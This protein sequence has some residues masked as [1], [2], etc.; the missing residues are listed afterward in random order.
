MIAIIDY[1]MG[2]LRS[3]QKAL[4]QAGARD[5][6][7]TQ[8][9]LDIRSATHVVL[10]GVGAIAPAMEKLRSLKMIEPVKDTVKMGKPFLGICLGFQLLFE[11]SFE[12]GTTEGLGILKGTV[13][14]F[15]DSVKVP[16]MGWNQLQLRPCALWNG[17][18][19]GEYVYFCH[20]FYVKP[21]DDRAIASTT[22]Y[23]TDYC[24]AV[25]KDNLFAVQFHP[26]KSQTAGLKILENFINLK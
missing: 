12:Y 19:N 13:E 20:S 10:P 16:Q 23:G 14:R 2:N 3:V 21:A 25:A 5:C 8:S 11:K 18:K 15:S 9:I 4:E 7:I 1:G 22:Q 17:I 24:S 6:R 26:E